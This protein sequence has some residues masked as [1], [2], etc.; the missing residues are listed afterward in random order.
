M[1]S[2]TVAQAETMFLESIGRHRSAN[3]VQTYRK[4]LETFSNLLVAQQIDPMNFPTNELTENSIIH[5]VDHMKDF[6]P[7]TESLYLQVIKSFYEF[8]DAE[9]LTLVNPS[10]VRLLIRK[11]TRRSRAQL[12][13]Y[14]EDDIKHLIEFMSNLQKISSLD[15]GA[16]DNSEL[17]NL[18]DR[19]LILT[20]AD[21]GL[22]V[23]EICKLGCGDIDWERSR[24]ILKGR[25]NKQAVVRFSKRAINALRDYLSH[26]ESLD[27]EAGKPLSSLPLF[28]RHDKG[29][30][31][32]I[33]PITSTTARRIVA[34]C[35]YQIL[36]REATGTITP[37]TFLHYFVT[38]ILRATGNL[39]LAQVLA[40]HSNIQVTQR[41]AHINEDELDKGYYEIFE[42]K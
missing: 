42:K 13:E 2:V 18:R 14:P 20:L 7:A 4:V 31:K 10:R 40:R 33:K 17:R 3:T 24:A 36:G 37:H 11:R 23:D 35:V 38:T 12:L 41:Y 16:T 27:L 15:H 26:R 8:L 22:R 1:P 25:G 5:F 29:A 32:K 30:G 28:A 21:T 9:N 19:A 39:K 34:E 6:S